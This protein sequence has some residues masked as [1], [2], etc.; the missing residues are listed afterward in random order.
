MVAAPDSLSLGAAPNT[1]VEVEVLMAAA[2]LTHTAA[3]RA[4]TEEAGLVAPFFVGGRW[5]LA[6][7]VRSNITLGAA[8]LT[9]GVHATL[10]GEVD[11]AFL[12]VAHTLLEL[13]Q[14]AVL[15]VSTFLLTQSLCRALLEPEKRHRTAGA[16]VAQRACAPVT[17]TLGTGPTGRTDAVAFLRFHGSRETPVTLA[18]CSG[19]VR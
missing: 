14:A 4:D 12:D 15:A 10:T 11:G 8:I 19:K 3:I 5:T 9:V 13:L 2:L 6:A 17:G 1:A 7:V 16:V 18:E